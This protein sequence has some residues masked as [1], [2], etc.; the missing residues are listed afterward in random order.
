LGTFSVRVTV[1]N[2]RIPEK[3]LSL[4]L[5]VDTGATYTI[6]PSRVLEALEV[7]PIRMVKLRLADGGI[8]ERPLGE[9]DIDIEGLAMKVSTCSEA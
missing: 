7:K 3:R 8:V 4:E 1:W 6:I 5:L 9:V 2:V